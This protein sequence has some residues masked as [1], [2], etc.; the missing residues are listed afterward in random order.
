MRP[1]LADV[2]DLEPH[3]EGGWYRRTWTSSDR[4]TTAD[5]RER[6]TA[7]S[8][9]FLLPA[10]ECSTWH[11]V[12]SHEIWL[13]HRGSVVLQLGGVG[14]DVVPGE[15]QTLGTDVAHGELAQ[16]VV[17]AGVWQRTLPSPVDALVSCVVSPGFEFADLEIR[18]GG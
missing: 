3:P 5:G 12:A 8:I 17:T 14:D 4:V 7:T 11:R 10:G 13:A 6:P 16:L 1:P 2:L 9:L 15:I 18:R